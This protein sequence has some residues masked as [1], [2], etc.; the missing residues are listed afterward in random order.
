[1]PRSLSAHEDQPLVDWDPAS[2]DLALLTQAIADGLVEYA[3][4]YAAYYEKC[5]RPDSP[6][7]RDPNPT[8]VLIPDWE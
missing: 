1:V 7:M 6:A 8:V 2:G 3:R 4:D 5:K